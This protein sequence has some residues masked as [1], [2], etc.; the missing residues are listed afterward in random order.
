MRPRTFILVL[1]HAVYTLLCPV[2]G[3][4]ALSEM[5]YAE[6]WQCRGR[7]HRRPAAS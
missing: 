5:R 7:V 4:K 1:M 2:C 3:G 6:A